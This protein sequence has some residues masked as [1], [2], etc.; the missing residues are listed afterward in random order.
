M[1][2]VEAV[3]TGGSS[4]LACP[5]AFSTP[6]VRIV[7]TSAPSSSTLNSCPFRCH[8]VISEMMP[9]R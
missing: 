7:R 2:R 4:Y 5:I 8:S 3:R 9:E 6:S 1:P